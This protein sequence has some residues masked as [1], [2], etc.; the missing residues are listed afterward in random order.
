MGKFI[1][2]LIIS[3]AVLIFGGRH[4]LADTV[5][6]NHNKVE[7]SIIEETS[8]HVVVETPIGN[9][10]IEKRLI[11]DI[12]R[13]KPE[14]NLL[15]Q[16]NYY[17]QR[18]EYETAISYY[19]KALELNPDYEEAKQS[20]ANVENTR[21][22]AELREKL[23]LEKLEKEKARKREDAEK[24]TGMK[25]DEE[26]DALRVISIADDSPAWRAQVKLYDKIVAVDK[27]Y[28]KDLR[29]EEI[30]DKFLQPDPVFL[31]MERKVSV[32]KRSLEYRKDKFIGIGIFLDTDERGIFVSSVIEGGPADEA[33]IKAGD[34]IVEI[35]GQTAK[36]LGVDKAAQII[37]DGQVYR[38]HM[39]MK[40]VLQIK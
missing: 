34:E 3:A 31:T 14:E 15:E 16:G 35:N 17:F 40:T 20:I 21:Q 9:V 7:G 1:F 37:V 22:E 33:G 28:V 23:K 8:E 13:V 30:W 25:F 29:L 32:T 36:S 38:V 4:V 6:F 24:K 10:T 26:A 5:Y 2:A 18:R 39:L 27:I 19:Q 12:K 11:T